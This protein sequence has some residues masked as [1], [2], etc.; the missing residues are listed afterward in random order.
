M[1]PCQLR[2]DRE[3]NRHIDQLK[4]DLENHP[5]MATTDFLNGY[6]AGLNEG[7]AITHEKLTRTNDRIITILRDA[8]RE[9]RRKRA[10]FENPTTLTLQHQG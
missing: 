8:V 9:S 1:Q 7:G 2:I 6:L 3:I 5:T 10:A 4:D